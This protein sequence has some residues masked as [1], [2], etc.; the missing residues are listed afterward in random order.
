MGELPSVTMTIRLDGIGVQLPD[1]TRRR[2]LDD[3]SCTV[4]ANSITL[5]V[6]Q[7]GAGK[8][9]LIDVL[10]GLR[11]PDTG[12]VWLEVP[13]RTDYRRATA[14]DL[15][16]QCSIMFQSPEAQLFAATI[17]KELAYNLRPFRLSAKQKRA[18]MTAGLEHAGLAS[19]WLAHS[20]ITL[21]HGQ[22]RRVSLACAFTA[23][24]P[25]LFLD[26]PTAG[27]DPAAR[28][29][30]AT[31][32]LEW[33]QQTCGSAVIATHDLS[34]FLPIADQIII[35][36]DGRLQAMMRPEDLYQAPDIL[37]KAGV[38]LPEQLKLALIL[39]RRGI[40][41]PING[42]PEEWAVAIH[43]QQHLP[44]S[45]PIDVVQDVMQ[46]ES[47]EVASDT[48][49]TASI[50]LIER[51][52]P[53]F[54]TLDARVKWVIYIMVSTG[55]LMQSTWLGIVVA[56]IMAAIIAKVVRTP[57]HELIRPMRPLLIFGVLAGAFA[58]LRIN[59]G[60]PQEPLL[61]FT[62]A[63][64]WTTEHQLF[65]L[66]I[67]LL[68]GRIL[69]LTTTAADLR[70]ALERATAR[71]PFAQTATEMLALS[72]SLLLRMLPLVSHEWSRF[73]R[74]VRSRAKSTVKAG[75]IAPL[76]A[77]ALLIPLLL[78]LLQR[79]EDLTLAMESRGYRQL[80]QRRLTLTSRPLTRHDWFALGVGCALFVTLMVLPHI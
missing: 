1:G 39:S 27:L 16:L 24:T 8:S 43:T 64:T 51:N 67:V 15:N 71:L 22:K 37:E 58:G 20:P 41:V 35:L 42:T 61:G 9:T 46:S 74:I 18:R 40:V 54:R 60:H 13:G 21:S 7:T 57:W 17:Q 5:L 72:A 3:I 53:T 78:A 11:S 48:T 45:T 73:S 34:T 2:L 25:W 59:I 63:H 14:R 29:E 47:A 49:I 50:S 26:E 31:G 77:P 28:K 62:W 79:A 76:D 55:T 69:T 80:G 44:K 19:D 56:F 6:G 4:P 70:R 75:R 68:Y 66:L 38:G 23:G 65:L 30:T 33:H 32:L 10:A 12:S 52:A 36:H